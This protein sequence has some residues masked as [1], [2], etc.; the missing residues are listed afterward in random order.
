[1]ESVVHNQEINIALNTFL[2]FILFN[3]IPPVYFIENDQNIFDLTC[4]W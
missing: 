1:M 4:N 2:C 3:Q